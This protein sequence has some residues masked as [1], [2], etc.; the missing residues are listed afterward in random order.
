MLYKS[1]SFSKKTENKESPLPYYF[2]DILYIDK[3]SNN[4]F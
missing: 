2:W 3:W 4:I 1:I